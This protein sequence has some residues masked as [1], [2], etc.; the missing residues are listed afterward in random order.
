MS[1]RA[2]VDEVRPSLPDGFSLGLVLARGLVLLAWNF[3][4]FL[5]MALVISLPAAAITV[6]LTM[7][8]PE[9]KISI[10]IDNGFHLQSSPAESAAFVLVCLLGLLTFLAVQTAVTHRTFGSMSGRRAGFGACLLRAFAALPSLAGAALV[11]VVTLGVIWGGRAYLMLSIF[12][13]TFSSTWMEF[14]GV[15]AALPPIFLAV[16]WSVF[17]P[18]LVVERAGPIGCFARSWT[19]TKG[20]RW[21]ILILLLLFS[22]LEYGLSYVLQFSLVMLGTQ[23]PLSF[24]GAAMLTTAYYHLR[25]EH[26]GPASVARVFD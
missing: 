15:V 8:L 5:G 1:L 16:V 2:G 25:V 23:V 7:V 14:A 11:L 26:D 17:L 13:A 20:R 19:L 10:Q 3:L 18:A 21:S 22:A 12:R 6:L 9:P 4:S 24:L